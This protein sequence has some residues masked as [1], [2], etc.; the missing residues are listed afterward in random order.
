[1][2]LS[3]THNICPLHSDAQNNTDHRSTSTSHSAETILL[4]LEGSEPFQPL[5]TWRCR[6]HYM[7]AIGCMLLRR[8]PT[9]KRNSLPDLSRRR[10][11]LQWDEMHLAD[12]SSQPHM[13]HLHWQRQYRP[14]IWKSSRG[15]WPCKINCPQHNLSSQA[16]STWHSGSRAPWAMPTETHSRGSPAASLWQPSTRKEANNYQGTQSL[17]GDSNPMKPGGR[18]HIALRRHMV[19]SI[20]GRSQGFF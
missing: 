1:M 20:K 12:R 4:C 16:S 19:Y 14:H 6:K 2:S 9:S 10:T 3:L 5:W 17:Q 11:Q 15:C 8:N 13:L 18:M 7:S